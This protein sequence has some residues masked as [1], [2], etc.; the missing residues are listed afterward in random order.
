MKTMILRL[1]TFFAVALFAVGMSAQNDVLNR[2]FGM[3]GGAGAGGCYYCDGG[4]DNTMY[5]SCA[6]A[7]SGGGGWQNCRIESYPE[8]TYC[9]VDGDECCVD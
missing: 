4:I 6:S 5:L 8:G 7:Q 1:I 9:F 3:G 2:D